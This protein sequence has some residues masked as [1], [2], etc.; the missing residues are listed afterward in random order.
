M[1][2]RRREREGDWNV[3]EDITAESV[4]NLKKE[5]YIRVKEAQR[6]P[7]K[8]NPSRSTW[9]H[10]I[11]TLAKVK[12]RILK[13]KRKTKRKRERKRKT[14]SQLQGNNHKVI[15]W[16][17]CRN[18]AGHREWHDILKVLRGKNLQPTTLHPARLSF[19]I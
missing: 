15:S 9:R 14:K 5:T 2:W 17:L 12:E 13:K 7:N 8:M 1:F 11:S 18:F 4:P 3:F 19:R 10:I 6:I 16:F